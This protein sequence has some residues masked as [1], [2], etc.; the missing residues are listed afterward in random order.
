MSGF[1]L[2]DRGAIDGRTTRGRIFDLQADH[3]AAAQLCG[4]CLD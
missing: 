4:R 3:M 2:A 1:A